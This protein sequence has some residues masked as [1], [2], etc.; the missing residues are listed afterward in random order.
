MT[1]KRVDYP[2]RLV[3][4]RIDVMSDRIVLFEDIPVLFNDRDWS[5]SKQW[6]Q[7]ESVR[8]EG[9]ARKAT[10][11][12]ASPP[13]QEIIS[14]ALCCPRYTLEREAPRVRPYAAA[15]DLP[16]AAEWHVVFRME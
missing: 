12:S 6:M 7:A 15:S 3:G 2:A 10:P 4:D 5:T 14:S 9:N 13:T 11:S 16:I 1:T 8:L